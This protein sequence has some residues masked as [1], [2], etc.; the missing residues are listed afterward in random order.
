MPVGCVIALLG[1]L[2]VWLIPTP[3]S[4]VAGFVIIGAGLAPVFPALIGLTPLR[5]GNVRAR[6]VIGWQMAAAGAGGLGIAA[7]TGVLLGQF[8]LSALGPIVVVLLVLVLA[9]NSVMDFLAARYRAQ[10]RGSTTTS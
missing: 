6:H 8:G 2:L 7:L 9:C 3:G 10:S 5:L 1:A 4:S